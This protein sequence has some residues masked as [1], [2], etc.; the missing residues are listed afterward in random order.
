MTKEELRK[1]IRARIGEMTDNEKEAASVSIC[2]QIIATPE[3]QKA[4]CVLLYAALQDEVNLCLLLKDAEKNGKRVY[5]PVVAGNEM[6]LKLYESKYGL[7]RGEFNIL[8]PAADA[9]ELECMDE[10]D[11]AIIPG[12]AFTADG[13]RLGRGRGYYDRILPSI[14]CAKWGVA[15]GSQLVAE[16]PSDPWDVRLDRVVTE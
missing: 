13:M 14:S 3:W 12:R 9:H 8:E 1:E 7:R 10:L 5:L 15:F 11:L 6:K 4:G 16:L 2:K